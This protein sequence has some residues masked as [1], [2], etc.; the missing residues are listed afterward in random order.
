MRTEMEG[1]SDERIGNRWRQIR[2]IRDVWKCALVNDV[3]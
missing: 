2:G 1:L 3:G